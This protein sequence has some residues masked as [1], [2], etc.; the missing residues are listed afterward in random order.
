MLRCLENSKTGL[1]RSVVGPVPSPV[2][3]IL[4]V[5]GRAKRLMLPCLE[6]LPRLR[7]VGPV[8]SPVIP[9]FIIYG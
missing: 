9:I 4:I 1:S 6:N 5:Y 7:N 3:L 8:P 2:I